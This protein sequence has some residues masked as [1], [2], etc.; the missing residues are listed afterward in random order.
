[1]DA[2]DI[3]LIED[4]HGDTHLVEQVFEDRSLPGELHTVDTGKAALDWLHQ[5]GDFT[6]APLP[7][8]IL[9]DLN[10]PA[11]SGH[12]LLEEIKSDAELRLI[13]VIILT[14]SKSDTDLVEA[15]EKSA[16]ACLTK[17]VDPDEF[18]DLFE[19]VT[20]FW[21]STAALPPDPKSRR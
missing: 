1:M 12:D 11:I 4:N 14:G 7:D 20:E 19:R 6:D 5:R 8:L 18:G 15:Y 9:L 2:V 13:P 10:L 17:P 3:L 21:V 16:N